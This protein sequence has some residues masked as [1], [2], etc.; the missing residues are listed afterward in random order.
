MVCN[1]KLLY[2]ARHLSQWALILMLGARMPVCLRLIV[3]QNTRHFLVSVIAKN[4]LV[5][6]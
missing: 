1:I 2:E 6:G 3:M 4:V 5:A